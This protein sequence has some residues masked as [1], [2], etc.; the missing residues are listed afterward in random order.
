MVA[1]R[2][3][4]FPADDLGR[5]T[6]DKTR[7]RARRRA[8][9]HLWCVIVLLVSATALQAADG[10]I[11]ASARPRSASPFWPWGSVPT[12]LAKFTFIP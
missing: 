3:V 7:S 9:W 8:R 10:V 11:R 4:E 2:V 12:G 6:Q 1:S 5:M